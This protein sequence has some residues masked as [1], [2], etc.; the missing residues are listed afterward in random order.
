MKSNDATRASAEAMPE[1]NR[2]RFLRGV[3][4]AAT[5]TA[6]A[7]PAAAAEPEMTPAEQAEWHCRELVRLIT[8]DGGRRV[9]VV[10]VAD[11]GDNRDYRDHGIISLRD[12]AVFRNDDGMFG[13][14]AVL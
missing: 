1:V 12:N 9:T 5:A 10:A 7:I 11:Y 6:V 2:R 3:A 14:K 4:G 8:Q 13:G